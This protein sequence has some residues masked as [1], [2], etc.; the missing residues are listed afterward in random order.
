MRFTRLFIFCY[1]SLSL[2]LVMELPAQ[3]VPDTAI[4][5]AGFKKPDTI[6]RASIDSFILKRRGLLGKLA[7]NLLSN[8]PTGDEVTGPIRNDLLFSIYNDRVIRSIQIVG[9]DFG[10][11][12]TDTSKTFKSRLTNLANGFHHKTRGFVI[13][14]NLF[15]EVGDRVF[16]YLLADNE[17]HLRDQSY[18]QDAR[19][20]IRS[21]DRSNDSVDITIF[22][23]DVLSIGGSF[24]MHNSQSV[25]GSIRED[26]LGGW[27]DRLQ[28]SVLYDQRRKERV[29][30]GGEFIKR[31]IGGSFIDGSIGYDNFNDAFN[32]GRDEEVTFYARLIRPLVNPYL[33]FTYAAEVASHRTEN[34][35]LN[36]STY[37]TDARYR[38]FNY[39]SW[40]G[41]NTGAYKLGKGQNENDRTRTLLSV[42]FFRKQFQEVPEVFSQEYYYD[43][44]DRMAALGSL[45]IFRQ[46]FY[47]V[48]YIYGFGRNEDVPEGMD[49]SLTAGWTKT[50]GRE[51]P[52]AGIDFQRFFFTEK[53]HYFNYTGRVGGYFNKN[54]LEDVDVLFNLDYFSNLQSLSKKWKQRTFVSAGI[55]LQANKELNEPLFLESQFGLPELR[56]TKK[57]YGEIRSTLKAESVF[58]SP[59]MFINFRF[60]PFIF[61]NL[62]LLT[63]EKQELN[64][65]DLYSSIGGGLRS[66][67]ES[68]IF[69]TLEF[70]AFSFR[71]RIILATAGG[72]KSIAVLNSSTTAN[73]L[74]APS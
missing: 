3:V 61:G 1:C 74:N 37:K 48:R 73:L 52:Y 10:T 21:S 7:R 14:N 43:Y 22:T 64:K 67:N 28:G 57:I 65:S 18:L 11:A 49:I 5:K 50:Q 33:R 27:G 13:R 53:E 8:N 17:R 71:V 42:R 16:P 44:I 2:L 46:D 56:N 24:R 35:Y 39:D 59:W 20:V 36:D 62:T 32:S 58:F 55:A 9:L 54:T 6:R 40:V 47:K 66:R 60:A 68:L 12:I 31:N 15:F 26:N 4:K 25:S 70:K 23:K 72:W 51:R 41:W 34:M 30:Y 38:Y 69:G 19:I 45:S 29:G 63:P